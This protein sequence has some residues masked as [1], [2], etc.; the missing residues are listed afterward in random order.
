MARA[1]GPHADAGT[2]PADGLD[3]SDGPTAGFLPDESVDEFGPEFVPQLVRPGKP[4][5]LNAPSVL[6]LNASYEPLHVCSIKRAVT[7][8]MDEAAERVEDA[9]AFLRSPST[10]F[11]VPSVIRLRRYVRRPPRY[12]VAFNRRNVFR[13]DGH[14]CQYCGRSGGDLTLDHV[15]PRSRGGR[16]TWEN[17][18]TACRECNSRK[19]DRTP[20]EARMHLT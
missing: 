12:H 5:N 18:V 7:L 15:L 8:L 19:R 11:P 6:V 4:L 2:S 9:P 14:T 16:N 13:R 17:I 20:E 3:G 10:N 1:S